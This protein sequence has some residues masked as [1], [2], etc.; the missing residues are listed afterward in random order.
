MKFKSLKLK[1]I[2]LFK[3]ASFKF[4]D[5][6]HVIRGKNRSGKSLF[7]SC[8]PTLFFSSPPLSSKKFNNRTIL[9]NGSIKLNVDNYSIKQIGNNGKVNYR[10]KKDGKD[11]KLRTISL[12]KDTIESIFPQ[13]PQQFYSYT[14]LNSLRSDGLLYATGPE[15]YKFFQNIF[16]LSIYDSIREKLAEKYNTIKEK[17]YEVK[18]LKEKQSK[19][20]INKKELININLIFKKL[21]KKSNILQKKLDSYTLEIQ[22][23]TSYTSIAKQLHYDLSPNNLKTLLLEKEEKYK[24]N[25]NKLQKCIEAKKQNELYLEVKKT[26]RKLEKKLSK[27]S[28][29][30]SIDRIKTEYNKLRVIKPDLEKQVNRFKNDLDILNE[31]GYKKAVK[32]KNIS[33]EK[34]DVKITSLYQSLSLKKECLRL[35]DTDKRDSSCPICENKINHKKLRIGLQKEIDSL[36]L[37]YKSLMKKKDDV[38]YLNGIDFEAKRKYIKSSDEL[39]KLESKLDILRQ[40]YRKTKEKDL[41]L[42]KLKSLPI[43][44]KSMDYKNIEEIRS[45]VKKLNNSIHKIKNDLK[46][47][48]R[49]KDLGDNNIDIKDAEIRLDRLITITSKYKKILRK[50]HDKLMEVSGSRSAMKLQYKELVEVSKKLDELKGIDE[51]SK[52]YENLLSVY[53][54]RGLRQRHIETFAQLYKNNLNSYSSY[55]FK[56]PIKFELQVGRNNFNIIAYRNNKSSDISLLSGSESRCFQ[57]L[58]CISLLSFVPKHLRSNVIILD[59]IEANMDRQSRELLS[60]EF[61]PLL[62]SI[63]PCVVIITPQNAQELFIDDCI[64]YQV[65]KS[66]NV[67]RL[68]RLQ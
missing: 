2:V 57:L 54:S 56:E 40:E 10:V 59:E 24:T 33:T 37:N 11:L 38:E 5:G 19:V 48:E 30:R 21:T 6:I 8:I 34:L 15:R 35:V 4:T 28:S 55:I 1:N 60:S 68:M 65:I 49:L 22:T 29:N 46:L 9:G 45:I 26:R 42:D 3:E 25:S 31:V 64:E 23:L 61:I 63:I 14:Y 18:S 17:S 51:E 67:S 12:A 20:I 50:C 32:L 36:S 43:I 47:H 7:F 41:I 62:K 39:Q 52:L 58:N 44:E 27:I 53:G 13:N 16:D 66:N